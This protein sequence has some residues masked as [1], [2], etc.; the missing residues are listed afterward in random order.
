MKKFRL[1]SNVITLMIYILLILFIIFGYKSIIQALE[2]EDLEMEVSQIYEIQNG[3]T[4]WNI[5]KD[6]KPEDMD[7]RE[8][9]FYVEQHNG[10]SADIK[11]GQKIELL[12]IKEG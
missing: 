12:K 5:C 10:I 4:L 11:A 1:L 2:G 6:F 7:L 3:D 9:I 8:Y